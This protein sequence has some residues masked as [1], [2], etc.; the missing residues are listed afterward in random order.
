MRRYLRIL[1]VTGIAERAFLMLTFSV[2]IEPRGPLHR[3]SANIDAVA[4][5]L[6]GDLTRL[7]A[8]QGVVL[9]VSRLEPRGML[10]FRK[11]AHLIRFC[12]NLVEAF[13]NVDLLCRFLGGYEGRH[14]RLL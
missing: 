14:D 2:R 10:Y 6:V 4:D 7:I 3:G 1:A 5:A 8:G 12:S 11:R 9:R 13:S